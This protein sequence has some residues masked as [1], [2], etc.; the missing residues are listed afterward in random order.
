[1]T[2]RVPLIAT[3]D[4]IRAL[5]FDHASDMIVLHHLDGRIF[6][7]NKSLCETLGYSY[8]ELRDMNA[9]DIVSPEHSL[10]ISEVFDE[11]VR[12]GELIFESVYVCKD[13]TRLP[14]EISARMVELSGN[15]F[16]LSVGRNIAQRKQEQQA[17]QQH[18]SRLAAEVEQSRERLSHNE[19]L[20][21]IGQLATSVSH[22]LRNPLGVLNNS[23]HYLSMILN[24][25]DNRSGKHL[26][27]MKREIEECRRIVDDLLDFS[28]EPVLQLEEVNLPSLIDAA[29]EKVEWPEHIRVR[30]VFGAEQISVK[31]D[32]QRV[33]QILVNLISNAIQAM[34]H[35]GT[36]SISMECNRKGATIRI[37]DSGVGIEPKVMSRIFEPLFTTKSKGIG[38]GLAL[39]K[40]LIDAHH[41]KISVDSIPQQGSTF[42]VWF[43][44]S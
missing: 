29:L 10:R 33:V 42:T 38:L 11:I 18:A 23:I 39:S 32:S 9:V 28:R 34:P 26:R 21:T 40:R 30:K 22:E 17:L 16:I 43:P 12:I 19:K 13:G 20:V 5:I 3:D 36:L 14:V 37:Q 31:V 27:I 1:M 4:K 35:G 15:D 25:E 7:A 2:E 6:D 8:D 24:Q 44:L 41:G